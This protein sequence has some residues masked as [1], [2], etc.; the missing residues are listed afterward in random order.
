VSEF[1][2]LLSRRAALLPDRVAIRVDGGGTLT[3]G[4]WDRRA[5]AVAGAL[6]GRGARIGLHFDNATYIDYAVAY[7]AVLRA[8]ATAV[9]LS[10]ALPDR[11]RARMEREAEVADV[12]RP[13][14]DVGSRRVRPPAA[15]RPDDLAEIL[16]TSG[17]T[18]A[19]KAVAVTHANLAGEIAPAEATH[20]PRATQLH[21]VPLGTNWG[22]F[23][24]RACL[25]AG[26]S[27]I[28]MPA[29]HA[30]R[31]L[32]LIARHRPSELLV[33]PPTALLLLAAAREFGAD[34]RSIATV[35][36]SGA[37]TR[38]AVVAELLRVFP[39]ASVHVGYSC[40]EASPACTMA[41]FPGDPPDSVGRA[42]AGCEVEVDGPR[43][44]V[45]LRASATPCRRYLNAD[46]EGVFEDG[47]VRTG[48][49]G[50]LDGDGYLRLRGRVAEVID[51]GGQAVHPDEVEAVLSE[52]PAVAGAAVV[53]IPSDLLGEQI[54]AAI[55]ASA[56]VDTVA[57]ARFA[58]ERLAAHKCPATIRVVE[59]LPIGPAG[60]V[61]KR[62]LRRLLRRP[63]R[64]SR[65]GAEVLLA[66]WRE[67][68][69]Q[70][71]LGLDDDLAARGADSLTAFAVHA[72]LGTT[73]PPSRFLVLPTVRAQAR[74]VA[75]V[76]AARCA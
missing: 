22:Q 21:A 38:P 2:A 48:D 65:A 72:R 26:I 15:V 6:A 41:E 30:A 49:L 66:L 55:V 54:A 35:R 71:D 67:A 75:D 16:F 20:D 1:A 4:E 34:T 68:L 31:A 14:L 3:F 59:E 58:R 24:L 56:P 44:E 76:S 25:S 50:R 73:L 33:A 69:E 51:V 53:G 23:A 37:P 39:E 36:L 10:R 13:P 74:A 9:P 27:S 40:T 52:H 63:A 5:C 62:E 19:P 42:P 47:W 45:R 28:V 57:V 70:D 8:G 43:G 64:V 60:K 29:F 18:G 11:E 46:G 7:V 12:L 17:S 32:E 61:S